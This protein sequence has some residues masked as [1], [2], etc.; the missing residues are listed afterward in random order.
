MPERCP[1]PRHRARGLL[2][3]LALAAFLAP[4]FTPAAASQRMPASGEVEVAFTPRDDAEKLLL[5]V[6]G[7]ARR[8]LQVQAYAFTSRRIADALVAA[9]ARGVAVEVLADA[10]MNQREKGNALPRLLAAGV[11]VALET[12]YAAAHNKLL[13]A[14]ADG[15]H[16]AVA[17]GSYNFTWSAQNRNAE[18]VL[19]L[20]DNC[21]LAGAYRDNWQRHRA[22]ATPITR[23]PW[24]P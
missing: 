8:S 14:D 6:I 5:K 21:A 19:V 24:K 15:P 3:A 2:A 20:R 11:P 22:Q 13:I 16:C 23:L 4:A 7:S 12:H 18:N 17:T 9:Q 10:K 1:G